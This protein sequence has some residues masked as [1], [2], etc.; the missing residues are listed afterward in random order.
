MS[1]YDG[2][3]AYNSSDEFP[4]PVIIEDIYPIC[5]LLVEVSLIW[6]NDDTWVS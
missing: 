5:F 2:Y 1:L 6:I 4:F 3:D